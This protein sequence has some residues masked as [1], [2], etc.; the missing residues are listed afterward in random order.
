MNASS[1][2]QTQVSQVFGTR[3]IATAPR[4]GT[5]IK[6]VFLNHD[7][8]VHFDMDAIGR[9]GGWFTEK[10]QA[11]GEKSMLRWEPITGRKQLELKAVAAANVLS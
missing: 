4:D 6:V 1:A 8:Y 7:L 2:L 10:N 5:W 11:V 3:K 9:R